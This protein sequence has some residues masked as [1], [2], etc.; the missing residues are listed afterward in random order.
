MHWKKKD[1]KEI[2]KLHLKLDEYWEKHI[3]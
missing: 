3:A 2:I 1:E